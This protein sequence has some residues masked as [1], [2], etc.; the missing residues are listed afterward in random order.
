MN[1]FTSIADSSFNGRISEANF[2]K[3]SITI[4]EKINL[5]MRANIVSLSN[6]ILFSPA[7]C[8][9]IPIYIKDS[10]VTIPPKYPNVELT[11][12]G[13]GILKNKNTKAT[14]KPNNGGGNNFFQSKVVTCLFLSFVSLLI[15]I[16]PNAQVETVFVT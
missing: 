5:P 14:I 6:F 2:I 15:S 8:K 13:T 1:V 4:G 3:T 7:L 11:K 16:A 9:T 12:A 10:G